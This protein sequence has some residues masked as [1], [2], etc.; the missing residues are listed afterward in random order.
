ME[1][2]LTAKEFAVLVRCAGLPLDVA[3]QAVLHGVHGRLEAMM[4]RVRTSSPGAVRDRAAEPAH[5]FVPG[6][7]SPTPGQ[8][9]PGQP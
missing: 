6:E 8:P 3:Q 1:S 7:A 4:Q 9:W 5:I 2:S